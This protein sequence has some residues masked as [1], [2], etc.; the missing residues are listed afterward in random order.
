[1][2]ESFFCE[3]KAPGGSSTQWTLNN[4]DDVILTSYNSDVHPKKWNLFDLR[5]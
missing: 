1:M 4:V 2:Q 3:L 5:K